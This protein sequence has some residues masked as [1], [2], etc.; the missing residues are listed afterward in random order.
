[1]N[2]ITMGSLAMERLKEYIVQGKIEMMFAVNP[3]N[4]LVE[5][6]FRKQM[7]DG[8]Y[9]QISYNMKDD[10]FEDGDSFVDG[11][12]YGVNILMDHVRRRRNKN[13]DSCDHNVY[14]LSDGKLV[15]IHC[16]GDMSL[17]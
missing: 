1:M 14:E 4:N 7:E 12:T 6:K 17:S 8:F 11:L 15:C 2:T 10:L 16:M 5:V 3:I 13:V 9:F